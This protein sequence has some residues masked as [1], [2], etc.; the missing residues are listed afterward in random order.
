M[1]KRKSLNVRH[2]DKEIRLP[3]LNDHIF[4]HFMKMIVLPCSNIK[5][6]HKAKCFYRIQCLTKQISTNLDRKHLYRLL[7][8]AEQSKCCTAGIRQYKLLHWKQPVFETSLQKL[9][10]KQFDLLKQMKK[11]KNDTG[12]YASAHLSHFASNRFIHFPKFIF[13][14]KCRNSI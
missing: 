11:K 2:F 10:K 8:Y 3:Y 14:S 9:H 12:R 6:T 5:Q 7:Y 13:T 4:Q 1:L